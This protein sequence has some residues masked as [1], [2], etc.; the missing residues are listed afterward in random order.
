MASCS[1]SKADFIIGGR[2]KLVR[3]IGSGSVGD[4]YLAINI[5]NR[6]EVAV[7]LE[8]QRVTQ[9]Q[10]L[11]KSEL[12]NILQGGVG[13]PQIRWYDQGTDYNVLI[14]DLL[15]ASLEDLFNF[16]SRSLR[17]KTV[18]MLAD[19]MVSRVKYVHTKNLIHRDIKPGEKHG[20]EILQ[21]IVIVKA[22]FH[23]DIREELFL[24]SF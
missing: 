7:K 20:I 2:Y 13:I 6:E 9:S 23:N 11:Y 16:C 1:G 22:S 15:G 3:K 24:V 17:M 14:M 5:T 21:F 8:S 12:Y 10:L 19:Q 4:I 18:L